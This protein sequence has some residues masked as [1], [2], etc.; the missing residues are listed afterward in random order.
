[1]RGFTLIEL[2]VVILLMSIVSLA[3]TEMI[4]FATESWQKTNS[5]QG[6]GSSARVAVERISR[7]LR[8][9]A[10][11]SVRVSGSGRCLEFVPVSAAATYLNLPVE[12]SGTAFRSVA[13]S[14]GQAGASGRVVVYPLASTAVYNTASGVIS[15]P[16]TLS[17]PDGNN[18]VTVTMSSAMQ[19]A[20]HSPRQRFFLVNDPVSFCVDSG[21][22]FRYQNYGISATQPSAGTLPSSMPDRAL[23]ADGIGDSTTPFSLATATLVRNAVV[24]LDMA[25][26]SSGEQTRV[27]HEVQLRNV[28]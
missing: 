25:F 1:M 23:L 8:G 6:I 9:A 10:P 20:G 21:Q 27:V 3:G 12:A 11:N 14:P 2:I 26:T 17:A 22:L 5:R 7:E 4:R 28:P 19:F 24:R 18:E 13:M 16:A 15:S